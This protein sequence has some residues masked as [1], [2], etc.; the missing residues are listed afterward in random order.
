MDKILREY[1]ETPEIAVISIR[2][3]GIICSTGVTDDSKPTYNGFGE[4]DDWS[5]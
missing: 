5:N 1:Y 2:S 4:E 3:E